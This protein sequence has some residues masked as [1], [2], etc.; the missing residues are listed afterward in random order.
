MGT[1]EQRDTG[2]GPPD[3]G[4]GHCSDDYIQNHVHFCWNGPGSSRWLP[5]ICYLCD[6][7]K[8]GPNQP[9]GPLQRARITPVT[10]NSIRKEPPVGNCEQ[11]DT[12][13][14]HPDKGR[15]HW[16]QVIFYD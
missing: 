7:E 8:K 5:K 6:A 16:F 11:R 13:Q 4:I 9:L 12:G 1:C 2:Q 15:K 14:G 3:K 10:R